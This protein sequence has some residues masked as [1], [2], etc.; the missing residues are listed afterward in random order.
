MKGRDNLKVHQGREVK[1]KTHKKC[2][3]PL[4]DHH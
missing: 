3:Q 4:R 2:I 1:V